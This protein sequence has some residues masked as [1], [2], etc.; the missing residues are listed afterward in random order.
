MGSAIAV[1][2]S[3]EVQAIAPRPVLTRQGHGLIS[4]LLRSVSVATEHRHLCPLLFCIRNREPIGALRVKHSIDAWPPVS[5]S[6][7]STIASTGLHTRG[8]AHAGEARL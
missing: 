6:P 5:R 8:I 1:S 7:H 3:I 4:L 2:R